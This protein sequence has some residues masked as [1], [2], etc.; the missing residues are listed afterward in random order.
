MTWKK[1]V[2]IYVMLGFAGIFLLYGLIHMGSFITEN[3]GSTIAV[4]RAK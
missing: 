3:W 4:E 2:A 1:E